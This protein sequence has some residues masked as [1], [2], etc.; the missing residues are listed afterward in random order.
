SCRRRSSRA[1]RSGEAPQ[2]RGIGEMSR[3]VLSCWGGSVTIVMN[4]YAIGPP[5]AMGVRPEFHEKLRCRMATFP[6][7]VATAEGWDTVGRDEQAASWRIDTQ[8][9]ARRARRLA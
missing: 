2:E 5:H 4:L 9:G 6:P 8:S 1:S 7:Q 3:R